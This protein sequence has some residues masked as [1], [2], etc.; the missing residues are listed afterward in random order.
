MFKVFLQVQESDEG[1]DRFVCLTEL[2]IG[3]FE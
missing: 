2:D 3:V 1:A